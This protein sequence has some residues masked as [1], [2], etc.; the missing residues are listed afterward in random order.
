MQL[1]LDIN[2]EVKTQNKMLDGMVTHTH[3]ASIPT[4]LSQAKYS[5]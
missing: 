1:T 4:A 5:T 2:Q 3:H